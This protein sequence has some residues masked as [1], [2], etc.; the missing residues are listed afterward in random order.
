MVRWRA[1]VRVFQH[2]GFSTLAREP[3]WRGQHFL[4]ELAS[5]CHDD[6][7]LR[8]PIVADGGQLERDYDSLSELSV[9]DVIHR[10]HE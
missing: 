7:R 9:N 4:Q 10:A 2:Q 6:C 5:S 8:V 3:T 1:V